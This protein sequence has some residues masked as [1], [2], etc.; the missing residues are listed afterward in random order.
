MGQKTEALI[1]ELEVCAKLLRSC[2]EDHWAK[3][4]EK[5]AAYLKQGQFRG[6][7]HFEGAFGGMGSINDLVLTPINGHT[8]NESEVD[9]YNNKM[10][11]HFNKAHDL[12]KEIRE[13]AVFK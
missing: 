11:E 6:I 3:W 7:D 2:S 12:I 13:N 9:F 10:R 4:L 8:I 1:L 5:S